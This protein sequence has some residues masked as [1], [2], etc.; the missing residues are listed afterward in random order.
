VMDPCFVI[1]DD[2]RRASYHK[3][4]NAVGRRPRIFVY[5]TL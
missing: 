5:A 3:D 2:S 1:R 4:P